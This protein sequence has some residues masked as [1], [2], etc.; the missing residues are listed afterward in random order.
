VLLP[1][2]TRSAAMLLQYAARAQC[3]DNRYLGAT[4]TVTCQPFM[5]PAPAPRQ[6]PRVISSVAR[7]G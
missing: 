4:L 1:Q 3:N 5:T 7:S 2:K 6:A